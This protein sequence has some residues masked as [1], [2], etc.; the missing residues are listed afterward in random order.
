MSYHGI[1][2]LE[3]ETRDE[4]EQPYEVIK[5]MGLENGDVVADIGAGSGYFSR[6]MAKAVAPD[7]KVYAVDIQPEM[8]EYLTEAAKGEGVENIEPV[9]GETADPK[10]PAASIDWMLLTDV[11]H[12]FQQPEPML[13]KMREALKPDGRIALIEYRLLGQT[14]QHIRIEHRMSIEQVKAEWEPAGFEL[15]E[16]HEFLP[17]QHFFIFKKDPDFDKESDAE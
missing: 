13:A 8:I 6:K 17:A 9:L 10:L 2:W 16:I 1:P 3:R 11:Y 15:V 14:A 7:G 4:E 12:E 5:T